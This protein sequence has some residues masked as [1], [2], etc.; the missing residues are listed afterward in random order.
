[1]LL[2]SVAVYVGVYVAVFARLNEC[3]FKSLIFGV[4]KIYLTLFNTLS[5][6]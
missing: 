5:T 1:M 2:L 3:K 6:H 4:V